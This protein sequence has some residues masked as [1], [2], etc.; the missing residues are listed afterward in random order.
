MKK[1]KI[2]KYDATVSFN[3]THACLKDLGHKILPNIEPPMCLLKQARVSHDL[4]RL[5]FVI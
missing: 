4:F 5:H 1:G 3:S 2:F